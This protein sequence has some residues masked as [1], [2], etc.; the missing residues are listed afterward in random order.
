RNSTDL[1]ER[2]ALGRE[3]IQF[4]AQQT[5]DTGPYGE[6]MRGFGKAIAAYSDSHILHDQMEAVNEPVNFQHFM[7]EASAHGMAYAGE[8]SV[9]PHAWTR[10]PSELRETVL[11]MSK[12]RIEQEQH[13]DFLLN[14]AFRESIL[15]RKEFGN[16]GAVSTS[17]LFSGLYIAGNPNEAPAGVDGQGR[18]LFQFSAAEQTAKISDPRAIAAIRHLRRAWPSAVPF[19]ELVNVAVGESP[20]RQPEYVEKTAMALAGAIQTCYA[21]RILE[22][23]NRPTSRISRIAGEYPLASRLARWQASNMQTVTSLRQKSV[24]VT[25]EIRQV[26]P[27]LDGS[28]NREALI[29]AVSAADFGS[30]AKTV[31]STLQYLA[32]ASLLMT[33]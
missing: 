33:N 32:Q 29:A 27:L 30:R 11:K 14:R 4:V 18:A 26:L 5:P 21:L 22:I 1:A 16:I 13:L 10:L 25:D 19:S 17:D 2:A 23:W 31:D 7:S 8:S 24:K 15:C 12:D 20:Q 6:M 28:R 3:I 9:W